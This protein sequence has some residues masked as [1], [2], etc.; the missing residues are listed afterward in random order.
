MKDSFHLLV[1]VTAHASTSH[2]QV[3]D[4]LMALVTS[5]GGLNKAKV[6][7]QRDEIISGLQ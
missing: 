4:K 1:N 5:Q 2:Q 3:V 6:N 7:E